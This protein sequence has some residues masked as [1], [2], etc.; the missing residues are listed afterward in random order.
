MD[1]TKFEIWL[2]GFTNLASDSMAELDADGK[3]AE[4]R[5]RWHNIG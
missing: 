1:R 4:F 2:D 5:E 3:C